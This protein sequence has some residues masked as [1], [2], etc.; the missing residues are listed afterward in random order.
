MNNLFALSVPGQGIGVQGPQGE[1]GIS[2]AQ[3][4]TGYVGVASAVRITDADSPYTVGDDTQVV[5][6]ST[7]SGTVSVVFPLGSQG[8]VIRVINTG[9]AGFQVLISPSGSETVRGSSLFPLNDG[10]SAEFHFDI[11]EYWW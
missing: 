2:G 6:A 11:T 5:F 8:K 4:A 10:Q 1:T 3:G 7:T 9:Q